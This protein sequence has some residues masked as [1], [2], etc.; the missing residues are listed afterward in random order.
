MSQSAG[1]SF[2]DTG[3]IIGALSRA[4]RRF[5]EAFPGVEAAQRGD[6]DACTSV[7]VLSESTGFCPSVSLIL[8]RMVL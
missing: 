5:A 1:R 4:G 7:G 3:V 6:F 8:C 2:L